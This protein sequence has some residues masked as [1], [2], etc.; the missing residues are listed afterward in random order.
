[1]TE[2]YEYLVDF[3]SKIYNFTSGLRIG[4]FYKAKALTIAIP[5]TK[6]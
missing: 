1:M 6:N 2:R 4:Y 5:F 3:S